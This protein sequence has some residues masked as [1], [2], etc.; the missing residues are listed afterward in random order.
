[1]FNSMLFLEPV[2][3]EDRRANPGLATPAEV[4]KL[5]PATFGICGSDPLRDEGILFAK[6]LHDNGYVLPLSGMQWMC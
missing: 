2:K 3:A 4:A 6:L 5:P 1:M